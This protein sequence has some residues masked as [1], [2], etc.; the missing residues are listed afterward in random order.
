MCFWIQH[1]GFRL[2]T[3]FAIAPS[4]PLSL[5]PTLSQRERELIDVCLGSAHGFQ[6]ADGFR[7]SPH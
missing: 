3:V 6:I 7:Y 1:M 4:S 5:T 2:L